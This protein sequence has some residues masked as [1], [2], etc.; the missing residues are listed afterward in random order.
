M[1]SLKKYKIVN[2]FTGAVISGY[3]FHKAAID[4][5]LALNAINNMEESNELNP[6][7]VERI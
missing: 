1:K 5:C 7:V 3:M 4:T 6:F 2:R